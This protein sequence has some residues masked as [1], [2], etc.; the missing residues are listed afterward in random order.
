M[1]PHYHDTLMIW[2]QQQHI[3]HHYERCVSHRVAHEEKHPVSSIQL[4]GF[5]G[6]FY[7]RNAVAKANYQF[8][9]DSL[10]SKDTTQKKPLDIRINS[11]IIRHGALTYDRLD[12]PQTNKKFNPAHLN[13]KDISTSMILKA[14]TDDSLNLN[15]KKLYFSEKSADFVSTDFLF[16]IVA[17]RQ[18]S[19]L[20]DFTLLL[21]HLD[22]RISHIDATYKYLKKTFIIASLEFNADE[23]I[24]S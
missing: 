9:L 15:V 1:K 16:K 13:I 6:L 10:A 7:K 5:K 17:N 8:V 24:L 12:M 21:P 20:S 23:Q 19:V 22:I 3:R 11:L 2:D 14:L 4:F 18:S